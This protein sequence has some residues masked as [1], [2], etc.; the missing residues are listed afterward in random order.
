L[1]F[2]NFYGKALLSDRDDAF[3][4]DNLNLKQGF[5]ACMVIGSVV[6][7]FGA[8]FAKFSS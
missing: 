7:G 5:D 1:N 3:G 4:E 2:D 8:D 6:R